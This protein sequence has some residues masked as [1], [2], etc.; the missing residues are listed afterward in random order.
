[1]NNVLYPLTYLGL[2]PFMIVLARALHS[3]Q[4]YQPT[5][6]AVTP[7]EAAFATNN[8]PADQMVGNLSPEILTDSDVLN[9]DEEYQAVYGFM[10]AKYGG[11][12]SIW[13]QRVN[14]L[15]RVVERTVQERNITLMILWNGNDCMGKVCQ[16]VAN[17]NG[18]KTVFLENG[19]FPNTLQIDPQGVNAEASIAHLPASEWLHGVPVASVQTPQAEAPIAPTATV[20]LSFIQRMKLKLTAKF[21]PGFY[22]QYPELRDQKIRKQVKTTMTFSSTASVLARKEAFALLVLQV[23]DDTQILLNSKLFNNPKDFLLHCYESVR[24]VFGPDYPVVIKLHPAD[25]GR[26]CYADVAET[27]QGV[28]WIGAE[29]VQP[30]LESCAFVMVVNSS[31]GLQSIALH[32]P[33]LV[34]GESFYSKDEVCSVIHSPDQTRQCLKELK[35]GNA[36]V[37]VGAADHFLAYLRT[38]FFVTG[39]WNVGPNT[40]LQP[41]VQR[42]QEILS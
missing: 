6:L 35:R 4:A 40:N 39:S 34:F 23:H 10:K 28:S 16:I 8:L 12:H 29:P 7:A 1:M 5:Y 2:C 36:E 25:M 20:P 26:I 32:K 13:R 19:Y 11:S 3:Q 37:D 22:D 15:Y 42:I 24:D 18:L 14:T 21:K 38:H 27:L 33:T 31:V 41:A 17:R 30:L 9:T